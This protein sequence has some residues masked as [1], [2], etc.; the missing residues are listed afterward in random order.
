MKASWEAYVQHINICNTLLR[1]D[2]C[3]LH[4]VRDLVSERV[5]ALSKLNITTIGAINW[6]GSKIRKHL[7][8]DAF[9]TWANHTMRGKGVIVYSDLPK[10]NS[11]VSNRKGLS[12]SEWTNA[13]KMSSNISAVRAISGRT[14]ST[15]RCRHPD[16]SE[17]ETL[18]HVLGQCPKGELLIKARHH[19][20]RHALATSLKTLNW[21]IHEEVHCVSSNGSFRRADIIAI[22]GRL[23]RALVLDTTIRFERNL[24]QA[25]EVDIEKKSIYEPCLPYLSQKYNVP[26]KQWSVIGL[27]FGSRGSITKF[28]WTYLKELHIPFDYCCFETILRST[29]SARER[30]GRRS[31]NDRGYSPGKGK[32]GWTVRRGSCAQLLGDMRTIRVLCMLAALLGPAVTQEAPDKKSLCYTHRKC[33]DCIR[34]SGCQWCADS[35]F[36]AGSNRCFEAGKI[37]CP[38]KFIYPKKNPN[39]FEITEDKQFSSEVLFRPQHVKLKLHV[40]EIICDAGSSCDINKHKSNE[41]AN[42]ASDYPSSPSS[43]SMDTAL[44]ISN[45]KELNKSLMPIEFPIKKRKL[46]R[47]RYPREKFQ[48]V[49]DFSATKVFHVEDA[50]SSLQKSAIFYF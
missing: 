31:T 7:R 3:H 19:R 6:S 42:R 26:L 29:M 9:H 25:N 28:T 13:L 33:R 48:K 14:L 30:K 41:S 36:T 16:C 50:S 46:Q 40:G 17:L 32:L 21:E 5:S 49:K 4:I 11:W 20:V 10:A 15:T 43:T 8:N 22:N 39:Q 23:K 12:S 1:V 24:N 2:D 37:A 47:K 35:I 18:G 34:T 27:L 44:E 38:A 45:I